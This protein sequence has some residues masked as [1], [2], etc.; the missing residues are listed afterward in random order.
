[1]NYESLILLVL[2]FIIFIGIPVGAILLIY[3]LI[4]KLIKY[5]S[6][7][8]SQQRAANIDTTKKP[9]TQADFERWKAVKEKLEDQG[10]FVDL[11]ELEKLFKRRR[12]A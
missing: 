11:D 6:D 8:K 7:C 4:K 9:F 10:G 3:V 1:M 12:T 2:L 5:N